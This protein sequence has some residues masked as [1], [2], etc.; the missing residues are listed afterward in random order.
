[1]T[2]NV[3]TLSHLKFTKVCSWPVQEKTILFPFLF[4]EQTLEQIII[5]TKYGENCEH[6]LK[7]F[8]SF[9]KDSKRKMLV[10]IFM[11][12]YQVKTRKSKFVFITLLPDFSWIKT[13]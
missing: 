5:I 13:K 4:F 7:A 3:F 10:Q 11:K 9:E 8:S 12:L 1:M 2:K 6:L